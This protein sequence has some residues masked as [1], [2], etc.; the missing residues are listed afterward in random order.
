MQDKPKLTECVK[1]SSS[2]AKETD[3]RWAKPLIAL[4]LP[5]SSTSH[6]SPADGD[7]NI[8]LPELE[9]STTSP[10][11]TDDSI[12]SPSTEG[13]ASLPLTPIYGIDSLA[14]SDLGTLVAQTS[15]D[16]FVTVPPIANII[17][18][19]QISTVQ[20]SEAPNMSSVF[21]L[22]PPRSRPQSISLSCI[23]STPRL[24][25][26]ATPLSYFPSTPRLTPQ[27]TPSL[28]TPSTSRPRL[29][30]TPLSGDSPSPAANPLHASTPI[31]TLIN[32]SPFSSPIQAPR[33]RAGRLAQL[34]RDHEVSHTIIHILTKA[35]GKLAAEV[36][37]MT[38]DGPLML[39]IHGTLRLINQ[40]Q[41]SVDSLR[42][43]LS[44][45]KNVA[46]ASNDVAAIIEENM[47]SLGLHMGIVSQCRE[48]MSSVAL[49]T[50]ASIAV[51][52]TLLAQAGH[53]RIIP[54][55]FYGVA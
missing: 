18:E 14:A 6:L 10:P 30:T 32:P 47:A 38:K 39:T 23:P 15:L 42:R 34:L 17:Q 12:A 5:E 49:D 44:L 13:E 19:A 46:K 50:E 33:N 53:E 54:R 31:D 51:I 1:S 35:Y 40:E 21:L 45:V 48:D 9:V 24:P 3:L 7:N 37:Q 27:A 2:Q 25:P 29:Q 41:W 28:C 55:Q 26:P 52:V 16:N 8:S 22:P 20:T 43:Q 36:L 4:S 11:S